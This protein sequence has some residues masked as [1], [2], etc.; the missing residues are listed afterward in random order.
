MKLRSLRHPSPVLRLHSRR[1]AN[2][3]AS[4]L[5]LEQ[6]RLGFDG[7]QFPQT[8]VVGATFDKDGPKVEPTLLLQE[9]NILLDKL[10]LKIDGIGGD[11][12]PLTVAN[13]PEHCWEKIGQGFASAGARLDNG[14]AFPG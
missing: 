10:F 3:L 5:F 8:E 2:S 4:S 1:A 12:D 14:H 11:D 6:G 9:G 13:G 7:L